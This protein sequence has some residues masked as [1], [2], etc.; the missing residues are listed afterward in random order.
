[1]V[2][3]HK[4][5]VRLEKS[6]SFFAEHSPTELGLVLQTVHACGASSFIFESEIHAL[7]PTI[8]FRMTGLNTF[9]GEPRRN[10][11]TESVARLNK[12]LPEANG[13]SFVRTDAVRPAAFLERWFTRRSDF[14]HKTRPQALVQARQLLPFMKFKACSLNKARINSCKMMAT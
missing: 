5:L 7:V 1:M 6:P 12:E 14:S 11:Q 2:R 3:C 10:H 8:L 9:D 13:T 4:N